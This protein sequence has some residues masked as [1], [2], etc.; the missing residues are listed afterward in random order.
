[1]P[2]GA[3]IDAA[4]DNADVKGVRRFADRLK[5]DSRVDVTMMQTVSAKG[6]DGFALAL[7]R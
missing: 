6:H 4:S 2:K 5:N 7:V 3:V 1:M